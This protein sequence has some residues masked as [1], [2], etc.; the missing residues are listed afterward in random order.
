MAIKKG[1]HWDS[2]LKKYF[3]FDE[4]PNVTSGN[5]PNAPSV[6]TQALVL[7][8]VAIDGSWKTPVAYY[9]TTH[10]NSKKLAELAKGILIE[11][12]QFDGSIRSIVFDGLPANIQMTTILGANLKLP[13]A[14]QAKASRVKR[15][16]SRQKELCYPVLRFLP[17]GNTSK[18]SRVCAEAQYRRVSGRYSAVS[19]RRTEIT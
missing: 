10:V 5:D 7:Y 18:H 4:F 9:F 2:K 19:S 8:L 11:S 12:S 17:N 1:I 16:N 15:T 14:I 3:G 6:A 13:E